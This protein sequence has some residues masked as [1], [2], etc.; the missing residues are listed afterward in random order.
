MAANLGARQ[1]SDALNRALW[2]VNRTLC[3]QLGFAFYQG[4][5][6]SRYARSFDRKGKSVQKEVKRRGAA[7]CAH[8]GSRLTL[9]LPVL[10]KTLGDHRDDTC[11]GEKGRRGR[12]GSARQIVSET[13]GVEQRPPTA[14]PGVWRTPGVWKS[15]RKECGAW[16]PGVSGEL[17]AAPLAGKKCPFL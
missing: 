10:D 15:G 7:C 5:W 4:L 1:R 14:T 12:Q 2:Q 9:P 17:K 6:G 16:S 13:P 3:Q 8:Q 11:P